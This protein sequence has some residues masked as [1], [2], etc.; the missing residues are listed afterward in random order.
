MK[1]SELKV[2]D[3]IIQESNGA[4][5]GRPLKI[6]DIKTY[7]GDLKIIGMGLYC[8]NFD[9][10]EKSHMFVKEDGSFEEITV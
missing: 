6:T 7:E 9:G 8:C 4:G 10:V 5:S 2:G 3:R 1:K